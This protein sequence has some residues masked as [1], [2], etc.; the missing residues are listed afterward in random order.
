MPTYDYRCQKCGHVWEARLNQGDTP[1]QSC[2]RC[3]S[4]ELQRLFP[5]PHVAKS[6]SR[7]GGRTCCGRE[8]RCTTPP[9]TTGGG[10]RKS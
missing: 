6:G 2:P 1:P 9:C 3:G 10:C 7:P 4:K 5:A 8:E